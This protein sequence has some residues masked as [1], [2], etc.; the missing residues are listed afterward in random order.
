VALSSSLPG[1][2]LAALLLLARGVFMPPAYALGQDQAQRQEDIRRARSWVFTERSIDL[3]LMLELSSRHFGVRIE[4]DA[5]KLQGEMPIQRGTPYSYEEI[6]QIANNELATRGFTTVQPPGSE[7]LRVV[8]LSEAASLAR[9][10]QLSLSGALAGYVKVLVALQH[11]TAETLVETVRLLLSKPGGSVTAVRDANAL[12]ISD[13]RAHV[14]EALLAI[15]LLDMPIVE[16]AV[17]EIPLTQATPLAVGSLIE[18]I[19]NTRKQVTGEALKGAALPLADARS[20]LIVAPPSEIDWWKDLVRRFDRPEQVTTVEYTPRR[21]GLNETAKLIEA[22]V[23]ANPA[24]EGPGSWYM[25]SD[26]LTGTLVITTTPTRHEAIK[27]LL[28]R[29]EATEMGPAWPVRTYPIKNRQVSEVQ[30]LLEGL[31]KA[32]VLEQGPPASQAGARPEPTLQGPTAPIPEKGK[33]QV[34]QARQGEAEVTLVA[35]E[36]TNRLIA[37]GEA[38]LLDQLEG[39]VAELDVRSAQVLVEAL[40]VSLN[41]S[42]ARDLGVELQKLGTSDGTIYK[43]GSLFGLGSPDP[44]LG[45]IPALEGS[46][47]TGAVLDPGDFSAVLRALETLNEGRSITVPKVLVNNNQQGTLDSTLQSPFASTNAS[48][49]VAT[50]SFGGTFDAGTV[51]TVKPQVADGDQIVMDYS[52][53]LSSFVGKPADPVLPPP[54]QQTKLQSVVTIPDGHTVVVGGLEAGTETDGRSQV[55]FLGS[56][57]L[58]GRLFQ[59][60]SES[61]SRSRFFVFLRCTVLRSATFEDLR[62]LS[63]PDLAAVGAEDGWPRLEPRIIR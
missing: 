62:F 14:A 33:A 17:V 13:L 8:P 21:F 44:S 9:L 47:F 24:G 26:G 45:S 56:V 60:R 12:V 7:S 53:A 30:E 29:V 10:E 6:W 3:P 43:L 20:I 2:A 36:S 34:A 5:E 31:L 58:V 49:T 40:V 52:V 39:L 54:R 38:R 22:V 59:S 28:E 19:V 1:P 35:D 61:Q 57:P 55:P 16:P 51:V 18:R 42:Q 41:E 48:T 11:R 4:F 15:R 23:H 37:F 25:V 50:T 63:A 46:G 27:E 32:G